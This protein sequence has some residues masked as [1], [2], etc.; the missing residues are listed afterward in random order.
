MIEVAARLGAGHETELVELVTGV[1]LT[2]LA[3]AA[4]LGQPLAA[5][6]IAVR[7]PDGIGGAATR[8]LV[9]PPGRLEAAEVPQAL[10]GVVSTRL[11]R[12]PGFV[13]G[14][15]LRVA[16][17]AGAVL[18]VGA[19]REEALVRAEAAAERI[20]FRHG[21]CRSDGLN[22]EEAL[23]PRP[24]DGC[25]DRPGRRVHRLEGQRPPGARHDR[26]GEPAAGFCSRRC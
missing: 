5:S 13:F 26:L 22:A 21:R 3:L 23:V 16:D 14:P 24:R 19:T 17:C 20:R 9:A 4:A 25:R 7:P 6:E 11:Y 2:A 18:A 8:F 15:P 1:D 10:S 12:E